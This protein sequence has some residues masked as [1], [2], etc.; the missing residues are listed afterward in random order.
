MVTE[1]SRKPLTVHEAKDLL[2][3][4][5]QEKADQIQKRTLDYMSKFSKLESKEARE[6]VEKL[7]EEAGLT[8][9]Q[10]VEV[11]NVLPKTREELRTFTVG[12]RQLSPTETLDKILQII[13]TYVQAPKA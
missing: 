6:V 11:V 1:V 2:A 12:W 8:E 4:V 7:V 13:S 3:K 5:D 9:L 10:A